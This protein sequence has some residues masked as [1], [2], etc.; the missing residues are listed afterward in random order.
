MDQWAPTRQLQLSSIPAGTTE[1]QLSDRFRPFGMIDVELL[2]PGEKQESSDLRAIVTF[3]DTSDKQRAMNEVDRSLYCT[4]RRKMRK[5]KI[6]GSS[7][8]S[9]KTEST[10]GSPTVLATPFDSPRP[11][12]V[13]LNSFLPEGMVPQPECQLP[14]GSL[15][16]SSFVDR[17]EESEQ[18]KTSMCQQVRSMPEA[19]LLAGVSC[20]NSRVSIGCVTAFLLLLSFLLLSTLLT[21]F[22]R[23]QLPREMPTCDCMFDDLASSTPLSCSFPLDAVPWACIDS[24]VEVLDKK[25]STFL[26]TVDELRACPYS[27]KRGVDV[28]VLKVLGVVEKSITEQVARPAQR[29]KLARVYQTLATI[30]HSLEDAHH[31]VALFNR[32]ANLCLQGST[33]EEM[34]C[35]G[36]SRLMLGHCRQYFFQDAG[37][38]NELFHQADEYFGKAREIY[39]GLSVQLHDVDLLEV[40]ALR[41]V[42]LGNYRQASPMLEKVLAFRRAHYG[43]KDPETGDAFGNLGL[44]YDQLLDHDQASEH[45]RKA[46]EIRLHLDGISGQMDCSSG[47]LT[48]TGYSHAHGA[49]LSG[50]SYY[51]GRSLVWFYR[52]LFYRGH[53]Q[54]AADGLACVANNSEFDGTLVAA[55]AAMC[56]ADILRISNHSVE[57]SRTWYNIALA[58]CSRK[59]TTELREIL[60]IR[61]ESLEILT[62]KLNYSQLCRWEASSTLPPRRVKMRFQP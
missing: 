55:H 9:G 50:I 10:I 52:N 60:H 19:T 6:K 21:L 28:N 44:T 46:V 49:C 37:Q 43:E 45:I 29:V 2:G 3:Q 39:G 33:L 18:P 16:N 54:Q 59:V 20:C 11:L 17:Q 13:L 38:A 48:L 34:L 24:L 4:Q 26:G 42:F 27:G 22:P 51:T 58:H 23:S 53:F 30:L 61:L 57:D 8:P 1:E 12:T 5:F 31:A 25:S 14:D 56:R 35:F 40:R 36:Q 32:S 41:E 15:S 62:A 7:P 47:S